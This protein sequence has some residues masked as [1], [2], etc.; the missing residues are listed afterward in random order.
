[1]MSLTL[2]RTHPTS[3][4]LLFNIH[5]PLLI[6]CDFPLSVDAFLLMATLTH[7]KSMASLSHEGE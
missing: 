3:L 1:M 6:A 7:N 2:G 5:P 4:A